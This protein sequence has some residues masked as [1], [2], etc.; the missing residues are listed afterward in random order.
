VV[1]YLK[2]EWFH[3]FAEEPVEVFSEVGDDGYEIRKVEV[4][5]DGQLEYADE[6]HEAMG[7][8]L[9]EVP[10][11]TVEDIAAQSEFRPHVISEQEFEETWARAIA[12]REG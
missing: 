12:A 5:R 9:S 11:G 2:V 3:D 1:W 4:F 10:V 7:T 6:H 8:R